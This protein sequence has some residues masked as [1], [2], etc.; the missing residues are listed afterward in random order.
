[1][2]SSAIPSQL[3][4]RKHIITVGGKKSIASNEMFA[5]TQKIWCYSVLMKKCLNGNFCGNSLEICWKFAGNSESAIDL[6]RC[7]HS[8]T[9]TEANWVNKNKY[10]INNHF[11]LIQLRINRQGIPYQL[12]PSTAIVIIST[13]LSQSHCECTNKPSLLRCG[14][15]D[16]KWKL[17]YGEVTIKML[18]MKINVVQECLI[19][20]SP[21]IYDT[22]S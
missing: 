3:G 18:I 2:Q 22:C 20:S 7:V 16:I 14:I 19:D 6:E 17:I 11:N 15:I 12:T 4:S 5:L 1:M 13:I 8:V 21:W 9:K 10:K